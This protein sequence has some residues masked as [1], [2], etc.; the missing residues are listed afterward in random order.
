M[1]LRV[2]LMLGSNVDAARQ[3]QAAC[4]R[5]RERF[6]LLAMSG[7]HPSPAAGHAG[8]PAYLNQAVVI[9]T[10]LGPDALK[11][12]LRAIETQLGRRRPNP[13]PHLC[14]I[15]IDALGRWEPDFVVWDARDYGAAHARGPLRDLGLG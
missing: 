14:P 3:L 15:D 13:E 8:A 4:G 1:P 9:A 10:D 5:L 6:E 2:L 12:A 11:L 7:P